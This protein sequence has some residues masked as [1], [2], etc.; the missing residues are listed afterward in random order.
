MKYEV[1]S[2]KFYLVSTNP[3]RVNTEDYLRKNLDMESFYRAPKNNKDLSITRQSQQ[4]LAPQR[5]L[6][7]EINLPD[8]IKASSY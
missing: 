7:A 6:Q 3:D 1:K 5:R 8:Q 4:I 2:P